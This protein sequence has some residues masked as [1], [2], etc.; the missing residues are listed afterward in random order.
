MTGE[1]VITIHQLLSLKPTIDVLDLDLNDLRFT[2]STLSDS[3]PAN[4]VLII[5]E[6]SMINVELYDFIG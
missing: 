1:S 2:S 4:G 5:D 6:C 3:V